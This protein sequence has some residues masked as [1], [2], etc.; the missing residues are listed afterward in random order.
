MAGRGESRGEGL[1]RRGGEQ[2]LLVFG[3]LNVTPDSFSDGGRFLDA[4]A[5]I[6][7]GLRLV[8]DGA[9]VVDV[10]GESTRPGGATYGEGYADVDASEEAR[11]V[12][13]V[14]RALA[15]QGVRVSVDTTKAEVARAALEAGASIVN[16]TA[17]GASDA[18]V[19][20]VAA[21]G[22]ELVLMHNR[23]RG[24]A[25]G[26]NV[27]YGDVVADVAAT[28]V[29]SAERAIARGVRR[30]RIW[31][32]PGLGF[33]KT[34]AQ[35]LRLHAALPSFVA[36]GYPVLLG[37]SRKSFLGAASARAGAPPPGPD[38]RLGATIASALAGA[39][40]GVRG[41]RVHDVFEVVQALRVSSAL[42]S[43]GETA[44]TAWP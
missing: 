17:C 3:V 28:L 38:A 9:D 16:D 33:A 1:G 37:A 12:V 5:A 24:E 14:V 44:G 19:D 22:A 34:A 23:G 15:M 32:D 13:P 40:A 4:G 18:L 29:A 30:E 43:A 27:V 10:G 7:H 26:E 11:R 41:V 20:A 2:A 42:A 8:E 39:R 35:S 6:A 25:R 21:H 31:L 36:L